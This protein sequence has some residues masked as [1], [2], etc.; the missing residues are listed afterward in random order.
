M[1]AWLLFQRLHKTR[2]FSLNENKAV[3]LE[4]Q[5]D[6]VAIRIL[7]GYFKQNNSTNKI[8]NLLLPLGIDGGVTF[9]GRGG[10]GL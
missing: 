10:W 7:I 4:T 6:L 5:F 3:S 8:S 9:G 2:S 1:K